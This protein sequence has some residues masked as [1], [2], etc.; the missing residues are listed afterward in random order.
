VY[1]L[2]AAAV[3]D[4]FIT[5]EVELHGISNQTETRTVVMRARTGNTVEFQNVKLSFTGSLFIGARLGSFEILHERD[6]DNYYYAPVDVAKVRCRGDTKEC[7]L[8]DRT[9]IQD[10]IRDKV[11]VDPIHEVRRDPSRALSLD[12]PVELN[13]TMVNTTNSDVGQMLVITTGTIRNQAPVL[14]LKLSHIAAQFS[15]EG[16]SS[17]T[18][19]QRTV[20]PLCLAYMQPAG[21][22]ACATGFWMRIRART[23]GGT[24]PARVHM[25]DPTGVQVGY[26]ITTESIIL[27]S[28]EQEYE[29][30]GFVGAPNATFDFVVETNGGEC[31]FEGV[32]WTSERSER[33]IPIDLRELE[34]VEEEGDFNP[35]L[36]GRPAPAPQ[37]DKLS[38]GIIAVIVLST[39]MVTLVV[40]HKLLRRFAG[41]DLVARFT[42]LL[43][44]RRK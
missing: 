26:G 3:N 8:S 37:D 24:G 42:R 11:L 21:C 32:S 43:H 39:L 35:A 27:T 2:P 44:N 28:E 20:Q 7:T 31:V 25:R 9:Y 4:V 41:I 5:L 29:I 34:I 36:T 1:A 10:A 12:Q 14:G 13:S 23:Q 17:L 22:Y 30:S 33:W 6:T 38:G 18:R 15:Y 16:T 19:V 40:A